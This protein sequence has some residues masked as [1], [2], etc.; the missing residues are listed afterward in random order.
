MAASM[1]DIGSAAGEVWRFL[2]ANGP[3]AADTVKRKLKLGSDV[4]YAAVGWLAREDKLD[5]RG[6]GR[7]LVLALK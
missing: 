1:Q 2:N 7:K 4:F 5:I 3:T 6:E